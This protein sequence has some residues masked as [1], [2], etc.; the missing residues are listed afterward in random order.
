MTFVCQS[1]ISCQNR[2]QKKKNSTANWV[3]SIGAKSGRFRFHFVFLSVGKKSNG[4]SWN[5]IFK[6]FFFL[7]LLKFS[8]FTSKNFVKIIFFATVLHRQFLYLFFFLNFGF[9]P[10]RPKSYLPPFLIHFVF[11]YTIV[12]FLNIFFVVFY[13][14]IIIRL[15][16]VRPASEH[17]F[18][19]S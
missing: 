12:F 1:K 15:V 8:F 6:Q 11:F 3:T 18:F 19:Q 7:L 4:L 13:F 16:P 5:I 14:V 17:V 10:T 9:L 2:K